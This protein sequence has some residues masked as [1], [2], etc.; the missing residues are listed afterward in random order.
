MKKIY[1]DDFLE[2]NMAVRLLVDFRDLNFAR[3]LVMSDVIKVVDE[4]NYTVYRNTNLKKLNLCNQDRKFITA[5]ID[6]LFRAGRCDIKICFEKKAYWNGLLHHIHYKPFNDASWQFVN[7]MRG[8]DN[9][10]VYSEFEKALLKKDI[11]EAATVLRE[12]KGSG[13]VLRNLN[14]LL[15]RCENEEDFQFVLDN[16]DANSVIILIQLLM[17][18]GN[19]SENEQGRFFKFTKHNQFIIHK[20]TPEEIARR[21]SYISDSAAEKICD[22]IYG[23]LKEN[24][25]GRLGKV[26]IDNSMKNIA[27]PLQET[28]ASGGYR[29]LP[30]GSRIHIEEGKK[31]RAFTYWEKIDD[32]D[33]SVIGITEDGREDEFSWRAMYGQQNNGITYSGDQTSG[34]HGGSEYYDISVDAFKKRYPDIRYLVFCDN[35]FSYGKTFRDGVCKAGYMTRDIQDSGK[36]FEPKTVESSFVINAD[37]SFAYL[38]GIDLKDNDFVWLNISNDSAEQGAGNA[39]MKFLVDYFNVTSIMNL[40]DFFAMLAA[41]I[42]DDPALADVVVSDRNVDVGMNTEVIKSYDFE[43]IFRFMQ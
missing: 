21:R 36:V 28:T 11:K 3:F 38:F 41:E 27:L 13:A 2:K 5:L 22:K 1:K 34:Y 7:L 35:V 24:L 33:L 10:S 18:Y 32:I 19:H 42:V 16:L 25:N 37:D 40:Y 4:I 6:L 43:K 23:N 39:E 15:S 14:Y 31:I 8:D 9:L 29:V 17:K 30:K 12:G 20:E 26:Y